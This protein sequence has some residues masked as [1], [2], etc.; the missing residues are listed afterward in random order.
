MN[1]E[2]VRSQISEGNHAGDAE[3]IEHLETCS[4]CRAYAHAQ[5]ELGRYFAAVRERAPEVQPSLDSSVFAAYRQ[6]I[7][8]R[9][10]TGNGLR[11]FRPLVWAAVAASVIITVLL[12]VANRK[13]P[14]S[15][16]PN[17]RTAIVPPAAT[18]KPAQKSEPPIK[19]VEVPRPAIRRNPRRVRRPESNDEAVAVAARAPRANGFQSLMF[20][21]P[22]SCP[23]PM[24]V[25]RI[26]VPASAMNRVPA[27]HPTGGMVQAD[28]V[29]GSD[30]IA[31]AIR[32]VR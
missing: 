27:W 21:D 28:V 15:N 24:Q 4:E 2:E 30:G 9:Q 16:S 22:L 31:R 12:L 8:K 23:G 20:C 32:I 7:E 25:I 5:D 6:K 19:A 26:Q 17:S 11:I 3:L 10:A 18:V 14:V 29:V 13:P 1:C